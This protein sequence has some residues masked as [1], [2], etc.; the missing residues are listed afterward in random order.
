MKIIKRIYYD[1]ITDELVIVTKQA[2]IFLINWKYT[3]EYKHENISFMR[4]APSRIDKFIYIG[5][6]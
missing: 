1:L 6:I 4:S 2:H 5:R 3:L